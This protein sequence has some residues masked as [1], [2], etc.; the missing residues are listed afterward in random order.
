M[1]D[2][3]EKG[4]FIVV[5]AEAEAHPEGSTPELNVKSGQR[6]SRGCRRERQLIVGEGPAFVRCAKGLAGN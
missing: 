2:S 6:Y 5:E 1:E 3:I 4:V